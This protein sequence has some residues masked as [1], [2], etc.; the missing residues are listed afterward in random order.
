MS[1]DLNNEI[2]EIKNVAM[3]KAI[4]EAK[5]KNTLQQNLMSEILLPSGRPKKYKSDEDR[6]LAIEKSKKKFY[7][8]KRNMK[9]IDDMKTNFLMLNAVQQ[10]DLIGELIKLV[11]FSI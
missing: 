3:K 11:N 1:N 9:M 7:E 2:N 4:S 5:I 6:N 10:I 8:K